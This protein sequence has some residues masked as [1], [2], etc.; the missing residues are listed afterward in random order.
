[1]LTPPSPWAAVPAHFYSFRDT[2]A[3]TSS[4]TL[5][6]DGVCIFTKM[7][8]AQDSLQLSPLSA[9]HPP[10]PQSRG[11]A[12]PAASLT[13]WLPARPRAARSS[14]SLPLLPCSLQCS[15][16]AVW[17]RREAARGDESWRSPAEDKLNP[18]EELQ[19]TPS[20]WREGLR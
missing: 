20:T 6:T 9:S 19:A 7:L 17:G 10:D 2:S 12:I 3:Q 5:P 16:T 1:M 11:R 4:C 14:S 8:A 18:L 15:A 13:G